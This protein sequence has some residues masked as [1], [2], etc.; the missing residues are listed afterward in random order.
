MMVNDVI[1]F[2]LPMAC[3]GAEPLL[4]MSDARFPEKAKQLSQHG[5]L[6]VLASSLWQKLEITVIDPEN[7]GTSVGPF[8]DA[9]KQSAR[10]VR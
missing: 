10:T 4:V 3:K 2:P 9:R 7:R 1:R 5:C 6:D 8:F